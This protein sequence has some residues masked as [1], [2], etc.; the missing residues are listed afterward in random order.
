MG[1]CCSNE[2]QNDLEQSMTAGYKT[3]GR[4]NKGKADLSRVPIYTVIKA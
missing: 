1:N 3:Q 4:K 2:T